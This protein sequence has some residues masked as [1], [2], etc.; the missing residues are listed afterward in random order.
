ML[1]FILKFLFTVG[2]VGGCHFLWKKVLDEEE[3]KQDMEDREDYMP[4]QQTYD[5]RNPYH[6]ASEHGALPILTVLV[7][8]FALLLISVMWGA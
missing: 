3:R 5:G 8:L 2:L 1:T 7:T 4:K 6:A